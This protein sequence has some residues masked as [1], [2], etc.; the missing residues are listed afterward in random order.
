M[1]DKLYRVINYL[2]K[3][4]WRLAGLVKAA[5]PFV[6]IFL[7]IAIG[8][9]VSVILLYYAYVFQG[10]TLGVMTALLFLLIVVSFRWEGRTISND[11]ATE[12]GRRKIFVSD[13]APGRIA[14]FFGAAIVIL[15]VAL[16][17]YYWI[18]FFLGI[19]VIAAEFCTIIFLNKL[20][21]AP[22]ASPSAEVI[23]TPATQDS[24]LQ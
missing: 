17:L 22:E 3:L 7:P 4:Y 19:I 11:L 8:A 14:Q 1:V 18:G 21:P 16:A 10:A 24:S 12:Y 9:F 23:S 5:F 2:E 6:L 20:Y 13:T 15:I